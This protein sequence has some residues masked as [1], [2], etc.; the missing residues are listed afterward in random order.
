[1][2]CA[3]FRLPCSFVT[4]T[5]LGSYA[6]QSQLGDYDVETHG[7]GY[8]YLKQMRFAPGQTEELLDKVA[9]LHRGQRY[10][11]TIYIFCTSI[12]LSSS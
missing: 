3:V 1:M 4:H 10:V 11:C 7:P 5:L 9:D 2:R 6:V 8:E 12:F